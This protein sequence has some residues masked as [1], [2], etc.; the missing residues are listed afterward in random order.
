[1]IGVENLVFAQKK[2][3]NGAKA[4]PIQILLEEGVIILIILRFSVYDKLDSWFINRLQFIV[5]SNRYTFTLRQG[6][7]HAYN[8]HQVEYQIIHYRHH[9]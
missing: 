1:M 9:Q 8:L 5:E 4:V 2:N 7:R 6:K 3:R